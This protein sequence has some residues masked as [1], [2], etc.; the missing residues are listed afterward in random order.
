MKRETGEEFREIFTYS[1][2][3]RTMVQ[4]LEMLE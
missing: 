2:F 4:N 3:K 1:N